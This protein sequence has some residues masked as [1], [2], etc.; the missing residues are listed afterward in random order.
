MTQ[1]PGTRIMHMMNTGFLCRCRRP[2]VMHMPII[3]TSHRLLV[4]PITLSTAKPAYLHNLISVLS[5]NRTRSSSMPMRRV[6]GCNTVVT[7]SFRF[8]DLIGF[9]IPWLDLSY[10]VRLVMCRGLL[11][12]TYILFLLL[13]WYVLHPFTL[14]SERI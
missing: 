11:L 13:F 9:W 12:R 10:T 5:P 14:I 8:A 6:Y 2:I 4:L 3:F 7:S 1:K